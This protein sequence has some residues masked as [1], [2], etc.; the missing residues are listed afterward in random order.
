[1]TTTKT[2]ELFVSTAN[3]CSVGTLIATAVVSD[4]FANEFS[5]EK[6]LPFLTLFARQPQN[7]KTMAQRFQFV[8]HLHPGHSQLN[9]LTNS[10]TALA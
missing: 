8:I 2:K 3:S 5:K 10:F 1:V 6:T 4:I 7:L 9:T